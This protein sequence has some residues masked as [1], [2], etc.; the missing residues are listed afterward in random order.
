MVENEQEPDGEPA[1]FVKV[2]GPVILASGDAVLGERPAEPEPAE[3]AAD[4][5]APVARPSPRAK[6]IS[7]I[8]FGPTSD[9]GAPTY[10]EGMV[11]LQVG[12]TVE[13]GGPDGGRPTVL[14]TFNVDRIWWVLKL[15]PYGFGAGP[16]GTALIAACRMALPSAMDGKMSRL[17]DALQAGRITDLALTRPPRGGAG[18]IAA[19]L[20]PRFL[21]PAMA[22]PTTWVGHRNGRPSI[23]LRVELA[24]EGDGL[25]ELAFNVG[26]RW[27]TAAISP[28]DA[29]ALGI[30][31]ICAAGATCGGAL[32]RYGNQAVDM[33][34]AGLAPFSYGTGG[35]PLGFFRLPDML[36]GSFEQEATDT[37]WRRGRI[38]EPSV[39]RFYIEAGARGGAE[40]VANGI[41][42]PVVGMPFDVWIAHAGAMDDAEHVAA[43]NMITARLEKRWA[44]LRAAEAMDA[45]RAAKARAA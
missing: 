36:H 28:G 14:L 43:V 42:T 12:F 15:E 31:M 8:S 21:P 20:V 7:R 30:L 17:L 27:L 33:I 16:L 18:M 39:P 26:A 24:K 34:R 45:E 10:F 22:N 35:T 11:P 4:E 44:A 2:G 13:L 32:D 37:L 29:M 38:P 40:A 25:I 5:P 19:E 23:Q 1:E 9:G 6:P 3:P 41:V